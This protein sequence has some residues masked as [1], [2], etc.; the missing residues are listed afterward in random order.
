MAREK[1][2]RTADNIQQNMAISQRPDMMR[3]L[4]AKNALVEQISQHLLVG[5]IYDLTWTV[6]ATELLQT[7]ENFNTKGRWMKLSNVPKLETDI[8]YC[9]RH[10]K[11]VCRNSRVLERNAGQLPKCWVAV[12][13]IPNECDLFVLIGI[14]KTLCFLCDLLKSTAYQRLYILS[15]INEVAEVTVRLETREPEQSRRDVRPDQ[16]GAQCKVEI[17]WKSLRG[18]HGH[19]EESHSNGPPRMRPLYNTAGLG[20]DLPH[21]S[22]PRHRLATNSHHRQRQ[23]EMTLSGEI[24]RMQGSTLC[25]PQK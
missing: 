16:E 25:H 3:T 18:R 19:S 23:I 20:F 14:K 8:S 17:D 4:C 9:V 5:L 1:A 22:S 21:E 2:Y 6:Q 11:I 13:D 24:L 10:I 7:M 15:V 12:S